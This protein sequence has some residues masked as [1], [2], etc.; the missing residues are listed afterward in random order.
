MA[1][2]LQ[3]MAYRRWNQSCLQPRSCWLHRQL[4]EGQP[5]ITRQAQH[6]SQGGIRTSLILRLL[7]KLL[8]G[9]VAGSVAG[10]GPGSHHPSCQPLSPLAAHLLLLPSQL[11]LRLLL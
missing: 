6:H 10:V 1:T 7:V 9:R 4:L 3:G 5:A 8:G 11:P 2:E